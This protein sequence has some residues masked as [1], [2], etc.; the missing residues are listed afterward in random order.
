MRQKKTKICEKCGKSF[1][2]YV[3]GFVPESNPSPYGIC[4][5]CKIKN[6]FKK[7]I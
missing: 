3:G 7:I 6:I 2:V 5:K 1:V 4:P